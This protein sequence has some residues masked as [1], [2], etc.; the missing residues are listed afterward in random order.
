MKGG[1]MTSQETE[2]CGE[3]GKREKEKERK[4]QGKVISQSET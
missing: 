3:R 2:D 1:E 4:K